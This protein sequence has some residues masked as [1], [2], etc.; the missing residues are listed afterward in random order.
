M[1]RP[2]SLQQTLSRK[3]RDALNKY[4][5][6]QG[7]DAGGSNDYNF[8]GIGKFLKENSANESIAGLA[9]KYDF[10]R[11]DAEA[12][13]RAV[14][15]GDR[16]YGLYARDQKRR[17]AS[18]QQKSIMD[19]QLRSADEFKANLP[20]YV[21]EES[22]QLRKSLAQQLA[23]TR[24]QIKA[25]ENARGMLFSGRRQASE[26][27]AADQTSQAYN[28]GVGGIISA[29]TNASQSMAANPL[30][31]KANLAEAQ[32][33]QNQFLQSVSDAKNQAAQ[34][35][36]GSGIGLIGSGIGSYLGSRGKMTSASPRDTV[37]GGQNYKGFG[38]IA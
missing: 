27:K 33:Q 21:S 26:G 38:N 3:E 6:G 7:V 20:Q 19:N 5:Y 30:K 37:I 24:G 11:M 12:I 16:G 10:G 23:E 2:P 36:M 18:A 28:Q 25:N 29:A 34:G 22:G 1:F 15:S 4:L 8:G 13:G 35:L 9:K 32:S 14:R 17:D 31:S